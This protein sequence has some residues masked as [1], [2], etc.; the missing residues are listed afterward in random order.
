MSVLGLYL[1][2]FN[3]SEVGVGG[4]LV[5]IYSVLGFVNVEPEWAGAVLEHRGDK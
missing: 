1:K 2:V 4:N 3:Q 5:G